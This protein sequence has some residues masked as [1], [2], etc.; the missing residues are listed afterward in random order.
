MSGAISN[1]KLLL[2]IRN[3]NAQGQHQQSAAGNSSISEDQKTFTL[4]Q[5]YVTDPLPPVRAQ[6]LALLQ[7]LIEKQSPLIDVP[8]TT[9]LVLSLLQDT[10]EY[11]YLF[12][13]KLLAL[14]ASN[15][16]DFVIEI[17]TETYED[18][19]GNVGLNQRLRLGEALQRTV[20][21]LGNIF[22]S[23]I[24]QKIGSVCIDIAGRRARRPKD[25]AAAEKKRKVEDQNQKEAE[26]AWGGEVPN[27]ELGDDELAERLASTL[28]G[29]QGKDGEEDIR[30]R[31]SALSVLATAIK[32]NL[33]SL[34]PDLASSGLDNAMAILT[35]ERGDGRAILRR[36]AVLLVLS[37]VKALDT[38]RDE[39][40]QLGFSFAG[41]RLD[42]VLRT[43]KYIEATDDDDLVKGHTRT[44]IEGL[45]DSTVKALL[46]VQH[47]LQ[48]SSLAGS[49]VGPLTGLTMRPDTD[50]GV[51]RI[52]EIE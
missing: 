37:L 27:L 24:A 23:D 10:E 19:E 34:G 38:A 43:L 9:I 47:P 51:R 25:A 17:L 49:F 11:I 39:G 4:S 6:G 14:L 2:E 40:Q 35:Q 36:A 18:K 22:G 12:A 33:E 50:V 21:R 32:T 20:E 5:I 26:Q 41:A 44:V 31:T 3:S 8:V 13:I 7:G 52:E 1:V 42:D 46:G 29:W 45:E 48:N 15:H 30:I 16:P 28:D